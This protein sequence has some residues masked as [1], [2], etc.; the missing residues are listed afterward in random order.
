M[1]EK[2]RVLDDRQTDLAPDD[3]ERMSGS[4]IP[5]ALWSALRAHQFECLDKVYLEW[6]RRKDGPHSVCAFVMMPSVPQNLLAD[7]TR[8]RGLDLVEAAAVP[9]GQT[10]LIVPD[11]SSLVRRTMDGRA[12]MRSYLAELDGASRNVLLG[13]S[14]WTWTYLAQT[15]AIEA[16]VSDARCFAPFRDKALAELIRAHMGD[17]V[18]KSA[19]SGNDILTE[20]G[21]GDLKDNYLKTLAARAYGCPWAAIRLLDAAVNR[22]AET[23]DRDNKDK[24]GKTDD[25]KD[26]KATWLQDQAVPQL[27]EHF[28]RIGHFVLH[29]LLIHGPLAGGDLDAVLPLS[30]P[31][32]VASA[33]GRLGLIDEDAGKISVRES[34]YPHVRRILSEAGLP[35]DRL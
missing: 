5:D 8:D 11:I 24:D 3:L 22:E 9:S 15:S 10:A 20:D 30:V 32:G 34:A 27:P 19:A 18:L 13:V 28:E 23:Q 16:V 25:D 7:W 17:E 35:L 29:A 26:D 1:W 14:S 33:L 6:A 31:V 21:D 12:A 4:L 2:L